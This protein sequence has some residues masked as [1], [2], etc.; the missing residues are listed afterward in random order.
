MKYQHAF[1]LLFLTAI[2]LLILSF[3]FARFYTSKIEPN[4]LNE[5]KQLSPLEQKMEEYI[6]AE[7]ICGHDNVAI[8]YKENKPIDFTCDDW[9]AAI[10]ATNPAMFKKQEMGT[11]R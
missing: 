2:T 3:L 8:S 7:S 11:Y 4:K 9:S 6:K 10:E 5:S 1:I